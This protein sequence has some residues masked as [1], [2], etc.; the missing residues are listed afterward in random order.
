MGNGNSQVTGDIM[1]LKTGCLSA[2]FAMFL[3]VASPSVLIHAGQAYAGE[4]A[5]T[6][7]N[8][9]GEQTQQSLDVNAI[10]NIPDLPQSVGVD[11][12]GYA[13][14]SGRG[15]TPAQ[16]NPLL[17]KSL[18]MT[19]LECAQ[20]YGPQFCACTKLEDGQEVCYHQTPSAGFYD[21]ATCETIWG[22]GQCV[23]D[24][25]GAWYH[26]SE[27]RSAEGTACLDK[28]YFFPGEKMEC[29]QSGIMTAGTNCCKEKSD[30]SNSCSFENVASELG[31][32]DIV[33]TALSI[34]MTIND[35]T[36]LTG[37]SLSQMAAKK[38]AGVIV[39][40]Y[41]KDGAAGIMADLAMLIG[42]SD[43]TH[44]IMQLSSTIG[45][46]SAT[47]VV[48]GTTSVAM[49]MATTAIAQTIATCMNII[50]WAYTAY[51]IYNMYTQLK[52][53]S[54]GEMILACKNAKNLC[55]NVGNRCK[56]KIFGICL[57]KIKVFCCFNTQLARIIHE[58]GRP[59]IGLGWGSAKKPKCRGFY[60][61]ELV[62]LDFGRM[63]FADYA[64]EIT[65]QMSDNIAPDIENAVKNAMENY[66]I[67]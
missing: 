31:M 24:S 41:V 43:A 63:D 26:P 50:S 52:K 67:Q 6:G 12:E 49:D 53:C 21:Q 45:S 66:K 18:I 4:T 5:G 15:Y 62:T 32:S 55:H 10:L 34:S 30:E 65:K 35:L 57:Q 58:Q 29:R 20:K 13:Q 42:P 61:N 28:V 11:A 19:S 39:E 27:T 7:E 38:V 16:K 47:A 25:S 48:Q 23:S 8:T 14:G 59:Q 3:Y 64:T 36:G 22:V 9:S 46:E 33:M 37:T 1:F 44:A 54:T 60:A 56:V 51:Q 17:G 2:L 40:S